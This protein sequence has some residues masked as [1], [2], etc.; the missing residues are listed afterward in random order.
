MSVQMSKF[1]LL[2]LLGIEVWDLTTQ[3][4]YMIFFIKLLSCFLD[5]FMST[6]LLYSHSSSF[7]FGVI[8]C[9]DIQFRIYSQGKAKSKTRWYWCLLPTP[10]QICT[11]SGKRKIEDSQIC[12]QL[13]NLN[14]LYREVHNFHTSNSYWKYFLL[15]IVPGEEWKQHRK[16][17]LRG[18]G[19]HLGHQ[20]ALFP[21]AQSNS[22]EL[23]LTTNRNSFLLHCWNTNY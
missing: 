15:L 13:P 3:M 17:D 8:F 9:Q 14:K 7:L 6:S 2:I 18:R 5:P 11:E 19:W 23:S 20:K 16:P 4:Q 21:K 10:L 22:V 12:D 1:L